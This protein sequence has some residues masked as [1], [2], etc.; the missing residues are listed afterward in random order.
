MKTIQ[1]PDYKLKVLEISVYFIPNQAQNLNSGF[2]TGCVWLQMHKLTLTSRFELFSVSTLH[3]VTE[4][5]SLCHWC[6]ECVSL[7]TS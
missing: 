7:R 5:L 4:T 6:V 2:V 1:S 3:Q